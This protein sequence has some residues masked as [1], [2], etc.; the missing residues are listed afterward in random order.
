MS[1]PNLPSELDAAAEP[2]DMIVRRLVRAIDYA[3]GFWLGFARCNLVDQRRKT[4][5][6]CRDLLAPLGIRLVEIELTE[7]VS[8]LLP[9]LKARITEEQSAKNAASEA[10]IAASETAGAHRQSKLAQFVYG[11]EHSI[12]SS[13]AYPPI[14]SHL[15]LNRELFRQ[16]ILCPLVIW[17]P[18]YALTALARRAPDFWAWRSGLYEFAPDAELAAHTL[19][20]IRGEELHTSMSLSEQAKRERLALLKGLLAD[21][22]ELG[23]STHERRVQSDILLKLGLM[24]GDLSEWREAN[25]AFQ[26]SL[27]IAREL[28]NRTRIAGLIH[29]LGILAQNTGDYEEA[30]RLYEQSLEI[31]RELDNRFGMAISLQSLGILAQEA[32]DYE[33]ARRLYEQSLKISYELGNRSVAANTLTGIAL[34]DESEGKYK[35]ALEHSKQAEEVFL[36]LGNS[37]HINRIKS[38][39]E[40]IEKKAADE[41]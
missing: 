39:L 13:E 15:N 20:P 41:E 34:L 32:G 11:L 37:K 29:N 27:A 35:E 26:E 14:L 31:A 18:E 21:Y 2:M 4:A 36:Q 1:A 8:E 5:T 28:G 10:T 25:Q 30:R 22:R 7:P 12:P 9:I 24:Y 23:D 19:E 6:V 3:E 40:R 16:E 17:L 33:E 38:I